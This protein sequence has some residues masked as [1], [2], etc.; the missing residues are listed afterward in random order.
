MNSDARLALAIAGI[1]GASG[2]LL[3]AWAGHAGAS[4]LD[5][6]MIRLVEIGVRYQMIHALALLALAGLITVAPGRLVGAAILLFALGIV[7]FCG[8]LYLLATTG[9]RWLGMVTP[10]G[11]LSFAAGWLALFAHAIRRRS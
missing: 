10:F 1:G 5:A 8:S 7:L 11:G 3:G 4:A 9:E 6:E 2:V